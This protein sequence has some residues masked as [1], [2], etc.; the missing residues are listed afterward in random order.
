MESHNAC[1]SSGQKNII[2]R[3]TPILFFPQSKNQIVLT[4]SLN[5]VYVE[6]DFYFEG[7]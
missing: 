2:C 4:S 1:L 6:H 5:D 3:S 7:K